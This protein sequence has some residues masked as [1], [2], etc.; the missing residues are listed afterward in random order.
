MQSRKILKFSHCF[1]FRRRKRGGRISVFPQF[2]SKI[3]SFIFKKC[4]HPQTHCSIFNTFEFSI[5]VFGLFWKEGFSQKLKG[6]IAPRIV[7]CLT[8]SF[9]P[10]QNWSRYA[11]G[12]AVDYFVF[13]SFDVHVCGLSDPS[14]RNC[15]NQK[16][17]KKRNCQLNTNLSTFRLKLKLRNKHENC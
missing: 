11:F 2:F 9:F 12:L 15:T 13:I 5:V 6:V 8:Y 10:H 14:W 7:N 17:E 4:F 3:F 1:L 16:N